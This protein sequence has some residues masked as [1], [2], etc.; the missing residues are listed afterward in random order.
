MYVVVGGTFLIH[1]TSRLYTLENL[2][3]YVSSLY[4]ALLTIH[5]WLIEWREWC[6]TVVRDGPTAALSSFLRTPQDAVWTLLVTFVAASMMIIFFIAPFRAGLWTGSRAKTH[7]LHRY[8]GLAFLIQYALAVIEFMTRY[9]SGAE[10]SLLPH[11]IALNGVIQS[12]SAYFSFKLLPE[13]EDAGYYSDKAVLSRNF[14]HENVY[15]SFLTIFGS[16]YYH[17][18][19]RVLIQSSWIGRLLEL[20]FVFFPYIVI[21]PFFPITR[22]KNAGTRRKGRS[23]ANQR[24]YELAT[25]A[26][27]IFYL[28]AKYFCGFYVNFMVYL[29]LLTDAHWKFVNGMFLLNVGT[30]SLAMFLHTLRFRK[31]L[32]PRF[33]FTVY[34]GQI[35]ATFSGIP[36]AWEFFK[37]HPKLG[38]VVAAG[39][40]CNMTRNRWIHGLWCFAACYLLSQ[41]EIEW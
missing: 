6:W 32:P 35:Y 23:D 36:L 10:L 33:T 20:I 29:N 19:A 37:S 27:K 18:R 24:F 34:L 11:A 8:M 41:A 22:F 17:P 38:A 28:W 9:G 1:A 13:A 7:K 5:G 3:S 39:V 30:V 26:V 25:Y 4:H 21:R 16:L 40:V 31:V 15:F 2:Q 12:C 14:V